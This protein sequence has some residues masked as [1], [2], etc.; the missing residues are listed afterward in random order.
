M[1]KTSNTELVYIYLLQIIV[2]KKGIVDNDPQGR[3]YWPPC[4]KSNNALNLKII[5]FLFILIHF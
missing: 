5:S 2:A 3:F 4:Q 1:T